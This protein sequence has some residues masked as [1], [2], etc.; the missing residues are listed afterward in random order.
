MASTRLTDMGAWMRRVDE[1]LRTTE[2]AAMQKRPRA[3]IS[4]EAALSQGTAQAS[5]SWDTEQYQTP[6]EN[7]IWAAG[8][9]TII[10]LRVPGWW[11]VTARV[12]WSAN[13]VGIRQL[14]LTGPAG[15]VYDVDQT[16]GESSGST[17]LHCDRLILSDGT[18]TLAVQTSHS[19]TTNPL[20]LV[21]GHRVCR[22]EVEYTGP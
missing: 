6:M 1:R 13:N 16:V 9:P 10:T 17:Y 11:H 7:A 8:N 19:S 20:P 2:F 15:V 22:V 18:F 21:V 12:A 3:V 5:I 14:L 4:R